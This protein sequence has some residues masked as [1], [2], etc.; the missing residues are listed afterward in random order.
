QWTSLRPSEHGSRVRQAISILLSLM[1]D[2]QP[3]IVVVEDLNWIDAESGVLLDRL[4]DSIASQPI[5]LLLTFRPDYSHTWSSRSNYGQ[6]RLDPLPGSDA[7]ALLA[8][9]LGDDASVGACLS[10]IAERTDG[11][12]L[13]LE[14]TI[15]ALAQSGGL[16]GRAGADVSVSASSG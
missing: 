1:A 7:E 12:P 2:T 15:Q 5:L 10:F 16:G 8:A 6:L 14:E 3:L 11:G 9:L 13:F 4:I